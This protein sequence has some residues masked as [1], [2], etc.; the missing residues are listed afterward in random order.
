MTDC[1]RCAAGSTDHGLDKRECAFQRMTSCVVSK[2]KVIRERREA[3]PDNWCCET[4]LALRNL[5]DER[6]EMGDLDTFHHRDDN[7][8]ATIWV[9]P[10]PGDVECASGYIVMTGYK[11]RGATPQAW[12]MHDD[13]DPQRLTLEVAEAVLDGYGR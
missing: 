5:A 6:A 9:L 12:V 4:L 3:D 2:G 10:I 1:K 8:N 13:Q 11:S 7:S